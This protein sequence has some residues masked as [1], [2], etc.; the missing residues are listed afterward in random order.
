MEQ[1]WVFV[2]FGIVIVDVG[3]FDIYGCSRWQLAGVFSSDH[4]Q[5]ET[6]L[7]LQ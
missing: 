6:A 5:F 7:Y 1:I 2:E 3:D 4:L